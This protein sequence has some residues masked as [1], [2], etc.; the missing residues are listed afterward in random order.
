[1]LDSSE[2]IAPNEVIAD[3]LL[4]VGDPGYKLGYTPGFYQERVKSVVHQD[5]AVAM[6]LFEKEVDIKYDASRLQVQLPADF[7]NP[8]QIYLHQGQCCGTGGTGFVILHWHRGMNNS[9]GGAAYTAERVENQNYDPDYQPVYQA[10]WTFYNNTYY[11]NISNGLLMLSPQCSSYQYVRLIYNTL[12]GPYDEIPFIPRVLKNF[13]LWKCIYDT[14][15]FLMNINPAKYR[16]LRQEAYEALYNRAHGYWWE[17][18]Y[19]AANVS[20]WKE[21]ENQNHNVTGKWYR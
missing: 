5:L 18:R 1:M 11:G 4:A 2:L 15:F 19:I 13:V 3:L 9:P 7:F 10:V 8:R 16:L 21:R 20:S 12:G 17:A 6:Y 14:C